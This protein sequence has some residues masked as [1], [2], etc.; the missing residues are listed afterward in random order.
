MLLVIMIIY[1][2]GVSLGG[3]ATNIYFLLAIRAI[4]GIG[5]SMFS[6]A[7]GIIRD[8]FQE[9]RYPLVKE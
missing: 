1:A 8:Q 3:F 2:A 4:Q 9:R 5:M 7:F 6:I